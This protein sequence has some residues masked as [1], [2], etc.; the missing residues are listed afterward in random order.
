MS[1]IQENKFAAGLAGGTLLGLIGLYFVGAH[2]SSTYQTAKEEYQVAADA[3]AGYEKIVPYPTS[4]NKDQKAKAIADYR[5]S[6]EALQQQFSKYQRKAETHIT[7]QEFASRLKQ[8][9]DELTK[10]FS[11][12]KVR[13]PP[14]YFSGFRT[15]RDALP[16]AGATAVLDFELEGIRKILGALANSGV[17]ELKNLHREQLPEEQKRAFAAGASD[18]SRPMP[19]EITFSG[20]EKAVRNFISKVATTDEYFAVIRAIRIDNVKKATPPKTS[21]VKFEEP[22]AAV[23]N[24]FEGFSDTTAPAA[25]K[26]ADDSRIL[27]QVLGNEELQVFLRIDLM[28]FLPA[29]KLP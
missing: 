17:S 5:A 26:P 14:E 22:K 21:D 6:I 18:V 15:Y 25:E 9:N 4:T 13:I 19:I 3:V 12:T 1:W 27:Q 10:E 8:A 7:P 2:G 28:Q 16:D 20:N 24:A 11:E 29:K 23:Q